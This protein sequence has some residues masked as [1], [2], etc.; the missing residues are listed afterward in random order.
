[1]GHTLST[2]QKSAVPASIID[3]KGGIRSD[4][5]SLSLRHLREAVDIFNTTLAAPE[6]LNKDEFDQVFGV[7]LGDAETHFELLSGRAELIATAGEEV[8]ASITQVDSTMVF[9]TLTMLVPAPL[10]TQLSFIYEFVTGSNAADAG[11]DADQLSKVMSQGVKGLCILLGAKPPEK[12]IFEKTSLFLIQ[13]A[14]NRSACPLVKRRHL[15]SYLE[16]DLMIMKFLHHAAEKVV[17]SGLD[18]AS[19]TNN[20]TNAALFKDSNAE[21]AQTIENDLNHSN[22]L[23][24]TRLKALSRTAWWESTSTRVIM[25][26]DWSCGLVLVSL[27]NVTHAG[28]SRGG[29]MKTI[30][31]NN[32]E[33]KGEKGEKGE[34]ESEQSNELK[35]DHHARDGEEHLHVIDIQHVGCAYVDCVGAVDHMLMMESFF[36]HLKIES[37][38]NIQ[39]IAQQASE[40]VLPRFEIQMKEEEKTENENNKMD[41]IKTKDKEKTK[42]LEKNSKKGKK[43]KKEKNGDGGHPQLFRSLSE[44]ILHCGKTWSTSRVCDR[45]KFWH[46]HEVHRVE[47]VEQKDIPMQYGQVVEEKEE[48]KESSKQY[49]IHRIRAYYHLYLE[50][51]LIHAYEAMIDSPHDDVTM[52][53]DMHADTNNSVSGQTWWHTAHDNQNT[54][55]HR[56]TSTRERLVLLG[57]HCDDI[58]H[59]LS[60]KD[61]LLALVDNEREWLEGCRYSTL[62]ELG[63]AMLSTS[64]LDIVPSSMSALDAFSKILNKKR[65][66]AVVDSE[67]TFMYALSEYDFVLLLDPSSVGELDFTKL[68][69][70]LNECSLL[71][72]PNQVCHEN[73]TLVS[74]IDTMLNCSKNKDIIICT[75]KNKPESMISPQDLFEL[76]VRIHEESV[77]IYRDNESMREASETRKNAIEEKANNKISKK[78]KKKMM[79]M[80]MVFAK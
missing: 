69:R 70:P 20:M 22:A 41:Q 5:G 52:D 80:K 31:E 43:L 1:M 55:P 6:R 58:V 13:D 11:F 76:I 2:K 15:L 56:K 63:Y 77:Y 27:R 39:L 74:V 47:E 33:E 17:G 3:G 73:D 9:L 72:N 28:V 12:S 16:A 60:D 21:T 42:E 50:Q 57:H 68:L 23:C 54:L 26:H 44:F 18:N 53:V 25:E 14:D 40:G 59:V 30:E 51:P 24:K 36:D 64:P 48:S 67:G 65:S 61:L 34:K 45:L 46:N 8:A 79:K 66:L 37:S 62:K 10:L 32:Q 29:T 19:V 71:S 7:M 49:Q 75:E 35:D 38:K 4:Y 78:K